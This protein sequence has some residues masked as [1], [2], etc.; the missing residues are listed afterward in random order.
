MNL[1]TMIADTTKALLLPSFP[2]PSSSVGSF[3]VSDV[4][5]TLVLDAVY[6]E[7][8]DAVALAHT[9]SFSPADLGNEYYQVLQ[10]IEHLLRQIPRYDHEVIYAES[11]KTS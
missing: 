4:Q 3:I 8:R 11:D 6:E 10:R 7:V 5:Q 2:A 9:E 1:F